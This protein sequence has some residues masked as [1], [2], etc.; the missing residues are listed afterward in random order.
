MCLHRVSIKISCV[1]FWKAFRHPS[2]LSKCLTKWTYFRRHILY[3][4]LPI[5]FANW[6][7]L[8]FLHLVFPLFKYC[9]ILVHSC[10]EF[11][12]RRQ[13]YII[14]MAL[15]WCEGCDKFT[16]SLF[17]AMTIMMG[18]KDEKILMRPIGVQNINP[19]KKAFSFFIFLSKFQ[20]FSQ[21]LGVWQFIKQCR[22]ITIFLRM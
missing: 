12:F 21:T 9:Y 16:L 8:N 13:L 11:R 20:S 14:C 19:I 5:A 3:D 10:M 6:T 1:S 4:F 22:T 15:I 2:S 17:E 18:V 7:L